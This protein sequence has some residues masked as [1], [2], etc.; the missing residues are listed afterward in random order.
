MAKSRS[1]DLKAVLEHELSPVPNSLAY[2]DSTLRKTQKSKLLHIL[3]SEVSTSESLPKSNSKYAWIYDGM[4]L[5]QKTKPT[6]QSTFGEYAD[7]LLG[8]I[9]KTFDIETCERIDVVFDRYD[10][11][12]S[13][14][15]SEKLRRQK[16]Q[17]LYINI[18]GHN[19]QLPKHRSKFMDVPRSKSNL[20]AFLC[21]YWSLHAATRIVDG[22]ILYLAGGFEDGVITKCIKT[23]SV[24][25]IPDLYTNQEE[26][27]TRMLL[28]AY[29]AMEE[30]PKITID[31][32]GMDVAV[33]CV[34][35][36]ERLAKVSEL[37]FYTGT[38]DKRR[39]IPVHD[40]SRALGSTLSSLL[41]PFHALTGCDSTSSVCKLGKKKPWKI[42]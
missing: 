7:L 27:D 23:N 16:T 42:L 3:E 2:L 11:K 19:T 21:S 17:G 1:V 20:A 22:K 31:S 18:H 29:H 32:P 25:N 8:I 9:L 39:F 28:H 10:N 12:M 40:I 26:A 33:L 24:E 13:I 35:Y 38:G 4:A 30:C 36:V 41:L 15:T 5:V 6:V 37:Y 14:K 34:Y